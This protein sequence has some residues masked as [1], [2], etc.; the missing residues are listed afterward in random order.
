[1]TTTEANNAIARE[2]REAEQG[3]TYRPPVENV[4]PSCLAKHCGTGL[5]CQTCRDASSRGQ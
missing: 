4:C 1:M 3:F 2:N 5:F